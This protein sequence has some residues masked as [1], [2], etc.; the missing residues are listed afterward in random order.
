[1]AKIKDIHANDIQR[2]QTE[3][4]SYRPTR[5]SVKPHIK[6]PRVWN[7]YHLAR[8]CLPWN[9]EGKQGRQRK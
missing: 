4:V 3:G 8:V 7:S 2:K 6:V 1:M 5:E 9:Q